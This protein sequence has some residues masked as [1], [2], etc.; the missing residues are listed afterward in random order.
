MLRHS[1]HE[2]KGQACMLRVPQHYTQLYSVVTNLF[3]ALQPVLFNF[4]VQVAALNINII[5]SF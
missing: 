5:G 2:R 4:A 1:K 3:P